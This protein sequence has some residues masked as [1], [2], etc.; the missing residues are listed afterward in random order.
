MAKKKRFFDP[1]SRFTQILTTIA[2]LIVLNALALVCCVPIITAGASVTALY[3]GVFRLKKGK[4]QYLWKDFFRDF[5]NNFRQS[6]AIWLIALALFV[7]LYLDYRIFSGIP[8]WSGVLQIVAYAVG[9]LLYLVLLCALALQSRFINSVRATIRNALLLSFSKLPYTLLV[10]AVTAL[11]FFL[12]SY[13]PMLFGIYVL[14]GASGT[15]WLCSGYLER[16]FAA[17]RVEES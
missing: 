5:K 3:A 14:L 17:V 4:E 11:P 15:A 10:G 12:I 9:I 16:I 13:V 2:D 1:D 7:L 6:T 8:G